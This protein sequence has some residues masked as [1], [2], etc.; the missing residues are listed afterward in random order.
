MID[1]RKCDGE[2]NIIYIFFRQIKEDW[3]E[4]AENF[5]VFFFFFFLLS[6]TLFWI[7]RDLKTFRSKCIIDIFWALFEIENVIESGKLIICP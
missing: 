1:K 2:T 5:N 4:E 6:L 7:E 3:L